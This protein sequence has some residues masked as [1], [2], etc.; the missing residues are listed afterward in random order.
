[1]VMSVARF[2]SLVYL[3]FFV[4]QNGVALEDDLLDFLEPALRRSQMLGR[5][6][7]FVGL[8]VWMAVDDQTTRLGAVHVEPLS[9]LGPLTIDLSIPGAPLHVTALGFQSQAVWVWPGQPQLA[10]IKQD[11]RIAVESRP[12]S[13]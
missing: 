11:T 5:L 1:M 8:S 12:T 10:D 7:Y 3:V 13:P 6:S 4:V 2:V 9:I